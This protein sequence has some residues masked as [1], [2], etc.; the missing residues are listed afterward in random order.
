MARAC[1]RLSDGVLTASV[2]GVIYEPFEA[3]S[4]LVEGL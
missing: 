1:L 4:Q 3:A 2:D